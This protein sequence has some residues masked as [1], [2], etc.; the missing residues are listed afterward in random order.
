MLALSSCR[1][2]LQCPNHCSLYILCSRYPTTPHKPA[3]WHLYTFAAVLCFFHLSEFCLAF[4]YM[5]D[6]LSSRCK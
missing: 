4:I 1:M 2:I 3:M 6:Q 5:R